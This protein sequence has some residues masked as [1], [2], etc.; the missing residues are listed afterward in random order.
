MDM[1]G[2]ARKGAEVRLG[3][4]QQEIRELEDFIKGEVVG[5]IEKLP[6]PKQRK[7]SA[8]ARKRMSL[9]AKKRWAEKEAARL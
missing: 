6:P 8:A 2:W 4:I 9:A 7:V 3:E 5:A 1:N